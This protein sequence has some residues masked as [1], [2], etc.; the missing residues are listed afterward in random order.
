MKL[1]YKLTLCLTFITTLISAQDSLYVYRNGV[2]MYKQ[3]VSEIDSVIFYGEKPEIINT[4]SVEDIDGNVYKTVTIGDQ[5]W[6]AENLKTTRLNDGTAI[7]NVTSMSTW[8]NTD[9]PGY[10]WFKDSEDAYKEPYGAIYNWY[11]VRTYKLCPTGWHVPRGSEWD[12]LIGFL[13][14]KDVAGGK[15][16]EKGDEFWYDPNTEATDEFGF[17][18]R[19]GAQRN[20]NGFYT[21]LRATGYWWDR[22]GNAYY[23][24]IHY[25]RSGYGSIQSELA[26]GNTGVSVRCIKD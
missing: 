22:S 5:V 12:T 24:Y 17:S 21:T 23:S 10:C 9:Q 6:M 19:G 7:A 2:V 8:K 20:K 15:L 11:T 16:K 14:G 4:G 26:G 25:I 13:G 18:A 1:M 3:E